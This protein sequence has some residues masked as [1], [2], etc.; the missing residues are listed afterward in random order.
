MVLLTLIT[1]KLK[2]VLKKNFDI[3]LDNVLDG[4]WEMPNEGSSNL[5]VNQ[6]EKRGKVVKSLKKATCQV[7]GS[8]PV[9][10]DPA[11][12]TGQDCGPSKATGHHGKWIGATL[13]QEGMALPPVAEDQN[14][15]EAFPKGAA[16]LHLPH[17]SVVLLTIVEISLSSPY[18]SSLIIT[19][20]FRRG[21]NWV[22]PDSSTLILSSLLFLYFQR[23]YSVLANIIIIMTI[24]SKTT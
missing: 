15:K 4:A 7:A 20:H 21:S 18:W 13:Q 2:Q 8:Y 22:I 16:L 17:C 23:I 9:E 11:L 3:D 12:A 24:M 5:C 6:T 14:V 19:S 1:K 10:L